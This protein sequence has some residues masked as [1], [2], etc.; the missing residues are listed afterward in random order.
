MLFRSTEIFQSS[1]GRLRTSAFR[2]STETLTSGHSCNLRRV[3]T[4]Y[5]RST[6][7]ELDAP[8][9][10]S[11]SS[12]PGAP[13]RINACD[14]EA[15]PVPASGIESMICSAARYRPPGILE[16]HAHWLTPMCSFIRETPRV[17]DTHLVLHHKA[18]TSESPRDPSRRHFR[19]SLY[20]YMLVDRHSSSKLQEKDRKMLFSVIVVNRD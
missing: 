6:P 20:S 2:S 15:R 8:T 19:N 10:A 14:V 16:L 5:R 4:F 9:P 12:P 11:P 3:G 13:V 17:F 18:S 7:C 1:T